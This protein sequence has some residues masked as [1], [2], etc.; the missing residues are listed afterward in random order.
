MKMGA[1]DSSETSVLLYKNTWFHISENTNNTLQW[2]H[3]FIYTGKMSLYS[4][5]L[6]REKW[7]RMTININIAE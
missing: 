1:V 5:I 3:K 6:F 2:L 4:F 7:I